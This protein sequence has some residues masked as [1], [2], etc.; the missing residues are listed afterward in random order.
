M[1]VGEGKLGAKHVRDHNEKI[2][3]GMVGAPIDDL[4]R[5]MQIDPR[6]LWNHENVEKL[7]VKFVSRQEGKVPAICSLACN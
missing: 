1:L 3:G 7:G 6:V 4:L 5:V 2:D